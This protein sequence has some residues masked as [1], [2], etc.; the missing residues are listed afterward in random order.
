MA[1]RAGARPPSAPALGLSGAA[2]ARVCAGA[3]AAIGVAGF[4][5]AAGAAGAP[6]Q[7]VPASRTSFPDWLAGP[8]GALGLDLPAGRFTA[9][10]LVMGAGYF[11]LLT[12]AEALSARLALAAVGVMHAIFLLGPPLRSVDVF[13]Y[14]SYARL[15]VVHGLDPYG[16]SPAAAPAD[17]AFAY[18]QSFRD[19]PSAYGPLFTLASYAVAPLGL[20]GGIWVLKAAFT[21]AS[22][23]C[24]ALVFRLARRLGRP[25]ATAALFVGL[26]PVLLVWSVGGAHNDQL[27]MLPALGG[28]ALAVAGREA[29]GAAALAGAAAVKATAGLFLPFMLAGATRRRLAL[30]ATLGSLAVVG[31]AAAAIFGGGMLDYLGELGRQGGFVSRESVPDALGRLLGLGGVTDGIRAAAAAT[32]C[33]TVVWLLVRTWRGA[34]WIAAAGWATLALLLTSTWV[35]PQYLAW[36]LPLAALGESG[37]LRAAALAATAA[38]LAGRLVL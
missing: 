16:H 25:P 14:L 20:A 17:P 24:V 6:S 2:K 12:C 23:G 9:L 34:D 7:A 18:L 11:A 10:V 22:L 5:L 4:L 38:V 15:E 30:G 35:L 29:A 37:R 27:M 31:G 8:F 28:L 21:A 32:L 33:A 19:R 36:L 26:N 1:T 3:L 13:A